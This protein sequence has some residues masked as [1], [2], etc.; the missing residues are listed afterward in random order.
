MESHILV[1]QSSQFQVSFTTYF[2]LFL[3]VNSSYIFFLKS[4]SCKSKYA[5][6]VTYTLLFP[7]I[8]DNT[9][10]EPPLSEN[11]LLKLLLNPCGVIFLFIFALANYPLKFLSKFPCSI[12]LFLLR[13]ENSK[14]LFCYNNIIANQKV[15]CWLSYSLWIFYY[16]SLLSLFFNMIISIFFSLTILFVEFVYQLFLLT[17]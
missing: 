2:S 1:V 16:F 15:E 3:M 8:L 6:S 17:H 13:V 11:L 7:N 12:F 4:S 14:S 9:K 10:I 5:F